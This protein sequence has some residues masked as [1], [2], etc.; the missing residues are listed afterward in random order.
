MNLLSGRV[1]SAGEAGL[2][3]ALDGV[4]GRC[5]E[6]PSPRRPAN[7]GD[8]VT[9]GMRPEHFSPPSEDGFEIELDVTFLE[10]L[11][12]TTLLHAPHHPAGPMVVESRD[13]APSKAGKVS[14]AIDPL[15]THLF[16]EDGE[17]LIR[18]P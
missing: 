14:V 15:H 6:L 9:V 7:P 1:H 10:N 4:E 17:T 8:T 5:L 3:V 18:R 16:A 2:S 12:A 11:G 13:T